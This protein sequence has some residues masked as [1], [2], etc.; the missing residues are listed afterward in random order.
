MK[1]TEIQRGGVMTSAGYPLLWKEVEPIPITPEIR[2]NN[3]CEHLKNLYLEMTDFEGKTD[4]ILLEIKYV[5]QL[6]HLLKLM[7]TDKEIKI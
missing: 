7:G 2:K 1:I 3:G 4:C 6:Q 5:H